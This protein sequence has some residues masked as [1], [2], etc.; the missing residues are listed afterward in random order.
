MFKL[1]LGSFAAAVAMFITGCVFVA[2]SIG[3]IA[4]TTASEAQTAAV[5]TALA[6]NLPKTGT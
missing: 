2:T 6:A 1:A 4:Y 5:Q 3:M